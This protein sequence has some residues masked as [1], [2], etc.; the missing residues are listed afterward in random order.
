[1]LVA[2][3]YDRDRVERLARSAVP[4]LERAEDHAGLV[5]VWMT[6]GWTANNRCRFAEWEY[7]A[8]QARRHARLAGEEPRHL[9][10]LEIALLYGPRPADEALR[11]LDAA[12]PESPDPWPLLHRA[13]LL[14]MLG[15]F[16][17][18]WPIA[19]ENSARYQEMSGSDCGQLLAD[20]AR[21][22][23]DDEAAAA[24]LRSYCD[25][26]EEHG[27]RAFISTYAP[28]CGRSL[29]ALGRYDEAEPLAE[30][31]R[32]LGDEQD[33]SAETLWRQVEALVQA[34]R[35]EYAEAERLAREAVAIS[36]KMDALNAQG[37]TL[38]DLAEVLRS[39][40]RID[41]AA[42][43]F[44]QAL[45]RYERKRNLVMGERVRVKLDDLHPSSAATA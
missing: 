44:E 27:Q 4:L 21:F 11:V 23:G 2:E 1:M 10:Y 8:E 13:V 39:A 32:E 5:D 34:S 18:A 9:F 22:A 16:E 30:L 24:Y 43:T 36:E 31:G 15:R 17:D 42:A 28:L 45:G 12:L 41:E 6:L 20:I 38:C 7:A 3:H 29:C 33:L 37:D 26:C 19:H 25:W 14:A 35:G 40:G